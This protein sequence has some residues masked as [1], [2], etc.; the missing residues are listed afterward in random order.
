MQGVAATTFFTQNT[1][2]R[3]L[4]ITTLDVD[5]LADALVLSDVRHCLFFGLSFDQASTAAGP[6]RTGIRMLERSYN[7]VF[8]RTWLEDCGLPIRMGEDGDCPNNQFLELGIRNTHFQPESRTVGSF[9]GTMAITQ[10]D[11]SAAPQLMVRGL[12]TDDFDYDLVDA[13]TDRAIVGA[14]TGPSRFIN[15]IELLVDAAGNPVWNTDQQHSLARV[16]TGS[17]PAAAAG[18]DGVVLIEDAGS[19]DQNLVVYS[20]GQ[21]FRIDGGT[22]F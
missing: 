13:A 6:F 9:T 18:M 5:N 22:A 12:I 20:D 2:V 8:I 7:N 17:L 4:R 11:V 21:R 15:R 16:A 1:S 14:S 3:S 19:G 10:E